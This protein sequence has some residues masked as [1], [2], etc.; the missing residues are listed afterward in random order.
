MKYIHVVVTVVLLLLAFIIV[1]QQ[2]KST[3][4]QLWKKKGKNPLDGCL[5]VYLDMGTNHGIQI[6]QV[7]ELSKTKRL[8]NFKP[9][10]Y[11]LMPIVYDKF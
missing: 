5:F 6:R 4:D 3:S 9:E 1:Q 7:K 8:L 11:L 10:F 2:Y